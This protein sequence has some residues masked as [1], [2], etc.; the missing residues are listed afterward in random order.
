[1]LQNT[2]RNLKQNTVAS[3]QKKS[4]PANS[5][6]QAIAINKQAVPFS[7]LEK[8]LLICIGLVA[9]FLMLSL[10][11]LRTSNAQKQRQI[12]DVSNQTQ[13]IIAQNSTL[14]QE[15]SELSSSSRLLQIAND[16][17]FTLQPNNIRNISK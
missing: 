12:Q 4:Q 1:M 13:T 3:P 5:V 17:H 6:R 11:N 15:I 10:V 7:G 8:G 9:V 16:H 2:A 14:R